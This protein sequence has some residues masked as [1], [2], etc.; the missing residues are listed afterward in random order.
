MEDTL[1][2]FKLLSEK[3]RLRIVA[4]LMEEDELCACQIRELLGLAGSTV[5]RHLAQMVDGKILLSRKDGRWVYFRIRK[6]MAISFPLEWL[7]KKLERDLRLQLD[8]QRL[9][10]ILLEDKEDIC[11]RQRL[12]DMPDV[13]FAMG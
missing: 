11:R 6:S 2:L 5:S 10:D 12:A 13:H 4:A 9:A 7:E 3:N 1:T 8:K